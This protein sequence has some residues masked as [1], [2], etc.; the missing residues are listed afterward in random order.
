MVATTELRPDGT[1]VRRIEIHAQAP[2]NAQ[3]GSV[4]MGPKADD[5][6]SLPV[7][8]AWTVTRTKKGT[9]LVI[10]AER[11]FKAAEVLP[12]DVKLKGLKG[13]IVL[14]NT[15]SIK[16]VSPGRWEY[17]ETL[18][19]NGER[20]DAFKQIPAEVKTAYKQSLP[21]GFATDANLQA[22]GETTLRELWRALFGPGDPLLAMV[23][24]HP[25]LAERK[26]MRRIGVVVNTA[27][28]E[29]FGDKLTQVQRG[30][31]VKKVVQQAIEDTKSTTK[32]KADPTAAAD[33]SPSA[34]T[35]MTFVI[36]LP[37]KIVSTNGE[38]DDVTGE[39]YW[40]LYSEAAAVGD[41]VMTATSDT[42]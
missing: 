38:R 27:L 4:S 35:A 33:S 22:L 28:V 17:R 30:D 9:D 11:T 3:G 37:G 7:A 13:V 41:V 20:P 36:K 34:L 15:L 10:K 23:I 21:A 25:D 8:P 12:S 42:N 32:S 14:T 1:I 19:W 18:H 6:F 26:V 24:M 29:R 5:V 16:Q 31:I 40:A 39:V 2:D